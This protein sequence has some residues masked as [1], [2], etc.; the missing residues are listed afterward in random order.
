MEKIRALLLVAKQLLFDKSFL[1]PETA[2]K[3]DAETDIDI[4]EGIFGTRSTNEIEKQTARRAIR[5]WLRRK[6]NTHT[7]TI[8]EYLKK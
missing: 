1:S 2:G 3:I 5:N 6:N 8:K 7:D 4:C